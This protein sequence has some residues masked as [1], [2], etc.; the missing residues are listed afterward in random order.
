MVEV[1]TQ[2]KGSCTKIMC[3]KEQGA[4]L[5]LCIWG[6]FRVLP[7]QVQESFPVEVT[8]GFLITLSPSLINGSVASSRVSFGSLGV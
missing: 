3:S 2:R 6:F 5:F 4:S 8:S 7:V 1:E